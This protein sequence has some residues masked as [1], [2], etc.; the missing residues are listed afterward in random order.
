MHLLRHLCGQLLE[1]A[2]GLHG[3]YYQLTRGSDAGGHAVAVELCPGCNEPLFDTDMR[4][5]A[6]MPLRLDTPT[7]WSIA[8]RAALAGLEQAGYGLR[9]E[10]GRWRVQAFESDQDSVSSGT[11][12]ALV[13]LATAISAGHTP[14]CLYWKGFSGTTKH[15][16]EGVYNAQAGTAL[17]QAG[18][19]PNEL[20]RVAID[21]WRTEI[22]GGSLTGT[23]VGRVW[24]RTSALIEVEFFVGDA[25]P[26]ASAPAVDQA[27]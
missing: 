23:H 22:A 20:I 26:S 15:T 2:T 24:R 14:I 5:L 27:G 1:R 4:D 19:G 16:W 6:G 25:P 10:D 13:E 12:D 18:D 3:T 8:R 17:G 9:W 7:A 21:G 11:L